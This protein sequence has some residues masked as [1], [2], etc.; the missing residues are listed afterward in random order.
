MKKHCLA[1]I[2]AGYRSV[3]LAKQLVTNYPERVDISAVAEPEETRR[4][5]FQEQ[6]HVAEERVFND[7][8]E[9][10]EQCSG[11]D[12][13]LILSKVH[14]HADMTCAFLEKKIPTFLEK[15]MTADIE[16][17]AQVVQAAKRTGTPLQIGFNMRY[18]NMAMIKEIADS[19]ELG[20][21]LS[22]EWKEEPGVSMFAGNY[23]RDI[24]YALR[25]SIGSFLLE[26]SCH[27]MDFI[28]WLMDSR[29]IRVASFGSRSYFNPRPDVP[30]ICTPE[31]PL[32]NECAFSLSKQGRC[33]RN[34]A[35]KIGGPHNMN[36]CVF[37]T[38][39]DLVDHQSV[40]LEYE[41]GGTAAFSLMPLGPG[42]RFARIM[43]TKA[44]LEFGDE[45]IRVFPH[46]GDKPAEYSTTAKT[47][48]DR[49][50]GGADPRIMKSF[51]DY[52]DDPKQ[53]PK[54][55]EQE[56]LESVLVAHGIDIAMRQKKVVELEPLRQAVENPK[57]LKELLDKC[58]E[59]DDT[60]RKS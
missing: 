20:H 26:K 24:N 14:Q 9:L 48:E 42:G 52:L 30:E 41:N 33:V 25:K 27:D 43:G 5:Y 3:C 54:T 36:T 16:Q 15:P 58:R 1:F 60:E 46:S 29:C 13:A 47:G 55:T 38:C 28:N 23:S 4:K 6:F 45:L 22:L 50:H 2:G 35:D 31:C 11:I 18:G 12:G 7:C 44:T 8:Y 51:L 21:I 59:S 49:G 19:G 39:S 57:L 32:E 53:K 40:I 34:K 17:A 10:L 56:G 37:H